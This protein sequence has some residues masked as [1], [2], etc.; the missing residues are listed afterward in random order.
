MLFYKDDYTSNNSIQVTTN[1]ESSYSSLSG[2]VYKAS[3]TY[4]NKCTF[5]E[6]DHVGS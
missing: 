2:I 4:N 1:L 6:D 3:G 5:Q